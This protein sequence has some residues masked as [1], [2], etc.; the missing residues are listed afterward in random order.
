MQVY[1][2]T[3]AMIQDGAD[4]S[5]FGPNG[6]FRAILS[7]PSEDRD[8]EEVKRTEW[9]EPLPEHCTLDMDHGMSAAETIG[10]FRPYFD[11]EKMMMEA[12]FSS[13]PRAQEMRTLVKEGHLRSVS[14]AFMRHKEKKASGE[15]YRELLNAGIVGVPSNRNAV[16]LASKAASALRDAFSDATDGDVPEDVKQAV[17]D[18]LNGRDEIKVADDAEAKDSPKPYGDVR[19]ADPE[20]GKYPIDT[21]AHIRAALAYIN[22]QKNYDALGDHAAHVKSAIEAAARSH[23]I[24]VADPHG[25]SAD[26]A[27]SKGIFVNVIPR[28][29]EDALKRVMG[30]IFT[31]AGAGGDAALL[32]AIHDAAGHLG[33][34]CPVIEVTDE[35]S[36]ADDGANKKLTQEAFEKGLDDALKPDESP[37]EAAAA[38]E[39]EPAPADD[40]AD[41]AKAKRMRSLALMQMSAEFTK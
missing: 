24:D 22:V 13:I 1:G 37:A 23:G 40:A 10:S 2:K 8:Y 41:T 5:E 25:K 32:Q 17:L 33:A 28:L 7:D 12:A 3:L 29:D 34:V 27:E 30:E 4:D 39:E 15:P 31:K 21:V 35:G 16:I 38:S 36:G 19:Y 11:G 14:V 6:G 9:I 18:A 26:E 20:D